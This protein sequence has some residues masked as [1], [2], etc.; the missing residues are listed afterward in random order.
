MSVLSSLNLSEEQ[1]R[2]LQGL[3]RA[4]NGDATWFKT[5][6]E[7]LSKDKPK[8]GN[9]YHGFWKHEQEHLYTEEGIIVSPSS[10]L[11][12][13][14]NSLSSSSFLPDTLDVDCYVPSIW[15]THN[16][17]IFSFWDKGGINLNSDK[18]RKFPSTFIISG[19]LS[20]PTVQGKIK[21]IFP[22]ITDRVRV[23]SNGK[24]FKKVN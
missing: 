19:G 22:K 8:P 4:S 17:T 23:M 5:Q 10:L 15:W 3:Y 1:V 7:K 9:Y 12:C 21:E 24:L 20:A 2:S 14:I 11:P 13:T 18:E 16:W 6:L